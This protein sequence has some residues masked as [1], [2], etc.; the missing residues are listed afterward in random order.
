MKGREQTRQ[1]HPR[2]YA[3]AESYGRRQ[4]RKDGEEEE[5]QT[6]VPSQ[7]NAGR[8]MESFGKGCL[9]EAPRVKWE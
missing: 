3:D 2:S 9:L 5:P 4:G 6:P 8:L 1:S 7:R